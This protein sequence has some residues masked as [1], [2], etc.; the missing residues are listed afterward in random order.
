MTPEYDS[1][2][3]AMPKVELHVHL[4]GAIEPGTVLALAKKNGVRL[5]ADTVEG[6]RDWYR[7]T[8]FD[9]FV[10]VY[11]TVSS[12]LT[13]FADI[14][15]IAREF[16]TGQAKQNV[17]H[18][19]FTYTAWNHYA[20]AGWSFD[21]QLAALNAARHWAAR[22]LDI[23]SGIVIDIPRIVSAEEG[24][25]IADWAI[26]GMGDGVVGLGLGGPEVGN[27]AERYV[28]A[29]DRAWDAGLP[30]VPHAG[31][32]V[33]P[34]S[35][36][37]AL[38]SLRAQRIGHGV[39]SIDDRHLVDELVRRRIPLEVCPTSNV[40][41]G[42]V[43]GLAAHPLPRLLKAGL[44]V[45]LNS[46]DP[47]MFNTSLTQEYL[48]CAKTFELEAEDFERLVLNAAEAS[49]L[50]PAKRVALA[51][52]IRQGCAQVRHSIDIAAKPKGGRS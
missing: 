4:E 38:R 45:T 19:E 11:L 35:V 17:R 23:S 36:W 6:L 46:D 50:T 42:G 12:C 37:G 26:S 41:V 27:P 47:P 44:T 40:C 5:P 1:F 33:G 32:T 28:E 21:D 34:E 52:D 20:R 39:R 7:F 9:H 10:E 16:L 30:A 29:F 14:E 22:E 49:L 15:T 8:D 51:D 18:T 24:V 48:A 3:R 25:T 31:E 43:P 13:T 2:L